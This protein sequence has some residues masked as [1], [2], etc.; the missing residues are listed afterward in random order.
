MGESLIWVHGVHNMTFG[1]DY[2]RQQINR[3]S[4]PNAR[5]QFTF[6]GA[7][8]A[9]LVNGIAATGTGF[10]FA[11]FLLG[12]PD[13]S[14]LRYSNNNSLYFRTANYDVYVTDDWRISQ[15]FSLNFGVRWDYGT[16]IT[17]KSTT[18]W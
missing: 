18:R 8:T 16:P 9:N 4:D 5:G 12:T 6:T 10:D 1:A 14:S 17:E 7:S 3:S 11:S 13:T 15:K 2:R